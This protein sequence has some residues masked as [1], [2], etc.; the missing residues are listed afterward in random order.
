[1]RFLSRLRWSWPIFHDFHSVL[2]VYDSLRIPMITTL[3][4]EFLGYARDARLL[5]LNIDDFGFCFTANTGA[6]ETLERGVAS[7]A[8][9]MLPRSEEHTSEL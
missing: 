6:I 9:V 8:T 3:T 5:I 4:S 1:V 2:M 7:S